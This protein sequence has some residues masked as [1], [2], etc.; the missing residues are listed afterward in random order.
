[1][2]LTIVLLSSTS[3]KKS[4]HLVPRDMS[5]LNNFLGRIRIMFYKSIIIYI[6]YGTLINVATMI[7]ASFNY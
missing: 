3:I 7:D 1:M 6:Q 5:L 2:L 4:V